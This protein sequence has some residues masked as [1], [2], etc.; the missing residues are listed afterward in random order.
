MTPPGKGETHE[1]RQSLLLL[2]A[3]PTIWALHFLGCYITVAIW[4]EKVAGRDGPLGGA[5]VAVAILTVLALLGIWLNARAGWR[6]HTFGS[7]TL[8][9]DFDTPEDRHR[10]LGFA[11]FLL[12]GLSAIAVI[13]VAI[14]ALF[15]SDCR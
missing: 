6:R 11:T 13:F 9:H 5:R 12:A 14:V 3:A 10:F 15:F 2:I 1:S 7:S 4:C 8:P